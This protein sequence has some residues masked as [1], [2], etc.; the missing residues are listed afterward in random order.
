MAFGNRA[1]QALTQYALA[2]QI[3]EWGW[4]I[5]PHTYGA[6]AVLEVGEAGLIIG[7]YCSIG[8]NVTIILGNHRA[9][10]VSTYPFKTLSHFWPSAEEGQADHSSKGDVVIGNDVWIGA[11]AT[12]MSGVTIGDG[13]VI[14]AQALVT[15]SVPPYAIVGGNPA[16]VIRYRFPESIIARLLALAWW[17]W[18][19][20]LVKERCGALM[21][22]DIEAFLELYEN[23]P[24][25]S[26]D[27]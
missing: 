19:E 13:A 10:L 2:Y 6:P 7:D 5:G 16:K 24:N 14:A 26:E 4:R 18:P 25:V 1:F 12:L 22:D 8:P 27:G 3:D 15:K 21:S 9:D 11:H 23:A 20:T 17:E